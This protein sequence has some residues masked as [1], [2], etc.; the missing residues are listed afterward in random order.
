MISTPV[1]SERL[2]AVLAPYA[3]PIGISFHSTTTRPTRFNASKPIATPDGRTGAVPAGCVFWMRAVDSLF[4][5]V[6]SDHANCSVGSFTHGLLSLEEAAQ[7]DDVATLLRSEWVAPED[8]SRIAHVDQRPKEITYG[9]LDHYD[10]VADVVLLR[11]NA[12][13]LMLVHDAW[14]ALR[15]EG[16]PQC[17]I[18]A[19]AL[20]SGTVA[21]SVG[22]M[23]S[24]TRTGM[25]PEELTL[26]IPGSI[27][28]EFLDALEKTTKV[29]STVA[30]YAARDSLRFSTP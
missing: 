23:L 3:P 27:L 4:A 25:G 9:P 30:A 18:V 8:F 16:K 13:A 19:L 12:K 28:H 29:D 14:P 15:I 24:R 1:L 17:H 5:T 2:T 11:I 7:G 6:A 20:E 22:C 26:A 21:A 10:Q